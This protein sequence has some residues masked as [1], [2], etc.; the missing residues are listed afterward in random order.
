[1]VL[2]STGERLGSRGGGLRSTWPAATKD[3]ESD[4]R[5]KKACFNQGVYNVDQHLINDWGRASDGGNG[6]RE[7]LHE[8]YRRQEAFSSM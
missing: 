2:S 1:M 6:D 4:E 5:A 7:G 8:V 3:E